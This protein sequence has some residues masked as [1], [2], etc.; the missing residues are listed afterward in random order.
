MVENVELDR[1]SKS[2]EEQSRRPRLFVSPSVEIVTTEL[3]F[4]S[5]EQEWNR[6]LEESSS[7]NVFLTW[8]WLSTWWEFFGK[9]SQLWVL[10]ARDPQSESIIGLMPVETKTLLL[11]IL[12]LA[13]KLSVETREKG[14]SSPG[15]NM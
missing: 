8:E 5:L 13:H 4:F 11:A 7:M 6:V 3:E 15:R 12:D 14:T 2:A 1:H 9:K 10:V